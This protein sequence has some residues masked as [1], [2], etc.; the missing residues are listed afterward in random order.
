VMVR[1]PGPRIGAHPCPSIP[2]K[3]FPEAVIVRA[4]GWSDAGIPDISVRR[5]VLPAAVA[6]QCAAVAAKVLWQ[7]LPGDGSAAFA[8]PRLRPLVE[9]V[10]WPGRSSRCGIGSVGSESA[11]NNGADR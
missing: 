4:P 6:I 3:R 8:I 1:R 5:V 9:R 2:R 10:R 7:I 11:R